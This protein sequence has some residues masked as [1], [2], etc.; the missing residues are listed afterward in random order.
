VEPGHV[1]TA[2]VTEGPYRFTRNPLYLGQ[3]LFLLGLGITAFPWL[4]L[5]AGVQALLLDRVVIPPEERRIAEHFGAAYEA[6]RH[7]VRRWI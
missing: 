6:Y 4:L 5:G 2:L 7:R 3:L 1:P